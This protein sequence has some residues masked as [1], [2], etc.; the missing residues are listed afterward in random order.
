MY[1]IAFPPAYSGSDWAQSVEVIN[2]KTNQPLEGELE[3]ALIELVVNDDC[4]HPVLRASSDDGSITVP[5]PGLIQ[6][7][8]SKEQIAGLCAGKTYAV[9]CRVTPVGGSAPLTRGM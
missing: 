3:T 5:E 9:G 4:N 8:F 7:R 1:D 6:W 2:D